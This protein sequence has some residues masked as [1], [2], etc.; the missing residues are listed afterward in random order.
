MAEQGTA[1]VVWIREGGLHP[2]LQQQRYTGGKGNKGGDGAAAEPVMVFRTS[3][4]EG[5]REGCWLWSGRGYHRRSTSLVQLASYFQQQEMEKEERGL[6]FFW[7]GEVG[8]GV[9]GEC[10]C[11]VH[12]RCSN[13][14]RAADTC[15]PQAS[16]QRWAGRGGVCCFL[17][18]VGFFRA[19]FPFGPHCQKMK[20]P[21]YAE[22]EG[23]ERRVSTRLE[24]TAAPSSHPSHAPLPR[25]SRSRALVPRW[26]AFRLCFC[27]RL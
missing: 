19:F 23:V 22:R 18:W 5:R 21:Q 11:V 24:H 9:R 2:H 20:K 15:P 13:R 8:W 27:R 1:E 26:G 7:V 14:T 25:R 16:E 3:R 12:S 17:R 6:Y 4:G 10:A